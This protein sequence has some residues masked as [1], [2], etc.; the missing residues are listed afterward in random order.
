[1]SDVSPN[2][3]NWELALYAENV[4]NEHYLTQVGSFSGFPQGVVND[5]VRF[6]IQGRI[7]F[8]G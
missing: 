7:K 3:A 4:F 6:G 5:P 2:D 1:V 8:G